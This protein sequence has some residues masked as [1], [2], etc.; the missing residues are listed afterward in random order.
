MTEWMVEVKETTR[1]EMEDYIEEKMQMWEGVDP[2]DYDIHDYNEIEISVLR[3]DNKHGIESYGW[4]GEDKMIVY[5]NEEGTDKKTRDEFIK[6]AHIIC[7][8][9]NNNG[10]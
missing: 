7:A 8:A 3:E 2:E 4:D 6:R 10:V 9:F 1:K 5:E